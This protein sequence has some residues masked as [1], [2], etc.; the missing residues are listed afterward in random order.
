LEEATDDVHASGDIWVE[1][2]DRRDFCLERSGALLI[3]DELFEI[4]G[5]RE[6]VDGEIGEAA[7][8]FAGRVVKLAEEGGIVAEGAFD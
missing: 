6:E 1:G 2:L 3:C 4:V 5:G 8:D 7:G